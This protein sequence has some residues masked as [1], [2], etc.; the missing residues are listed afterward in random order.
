MH[1]LVCDEVLTKQQFYPM[2]VLKSEGFMSLEIE[3]QV[4]SLDVLKPIILYEPFFN[5]NFTFLGFKELNSFDPLMEVFSKVSLRSDST[6]GGLG[7]VSPV[8]VNLIKEKGYYLKSCSKVDSSRVKD[9]AHP[10]VMV[11]AYHG[12]FVNLQEKDPF[13]SL[14]HQSGALRAMAAHYRFSP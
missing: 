8:K 3:E 2:D 13:V 9:V 14:E 11:D 5:E 6:L 12:V 10:G 4:L 7:F 1:N